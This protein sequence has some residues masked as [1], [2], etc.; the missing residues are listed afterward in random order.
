MRGEAKTVAESCVDVCGCEKEGGE[1]DRSR[2]ELDAQ[3]KRE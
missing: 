2:K 3:G 1:E